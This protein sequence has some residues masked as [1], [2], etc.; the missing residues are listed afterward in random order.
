MTT[1]EIFAHI[2][3]LKGTFAFAISGALAA[4]NRRLDLFGI[5]VLSFV[6]GNV[7]GITRDVLIGAVPP[8]AL[9]DVSC[10]LVSLLA[11]LSPS[12]PMQAP[13]ACGT[14]CSC[15]TPRGWRSSRLPARTR[16]WRSASGTSLPLFSAC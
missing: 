12:S 4:A 6:A 10:V 8:A 3:D 2:L 13:T 15:S 11:G 5:L 16:R 7:G 14:P 9:A 1:V